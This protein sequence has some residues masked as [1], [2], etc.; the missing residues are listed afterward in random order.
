[1]RAPTLLELA[2]NFVEATSD[3]AKAGCPISSEEEYRRRQA[4]CNGCKYWNANAWQGIGRCMKCGC[5]GSKRWMKTAHCPLRIWEGQPYG[6][7]AREEV[8]NPSSEP[9]NASQ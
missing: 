7:A 9:P 1:M 6:D 4:L 2:S 8:S 5:S 3:W